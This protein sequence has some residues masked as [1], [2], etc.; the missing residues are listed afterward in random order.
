MRNLDRL[1]A[2]VAAAFPLGG[3]TIA[4]FS[5]GPSYALSLGLA[6]GD[7]FDSVIAFSPGFQVAE[8]AG[9]R[10]GLFVS[11]GTEDEHGGSA[12][13]SHRRLTGTGCMAGWPCSRPVVTSPYKSLSACLGRRE[14]A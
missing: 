13:G 8:S 7:V 10:P 12:R 3:Y 6:N 14:L 4:G 5:D 11:H 2:E 1:L 9:G